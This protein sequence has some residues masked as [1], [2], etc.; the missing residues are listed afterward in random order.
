[1]QLRLRGLPSRGSVELATLSTGEVKSSG[2]EK[3]IG[4]FFLILIQRRIRVPLEVVRAH[5]PWR[6]SASK[7][8]SVHKKQNQ[9]G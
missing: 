8:L 6:N 5:P 4:F 3:E 2:K 1:M 9:D 7:E